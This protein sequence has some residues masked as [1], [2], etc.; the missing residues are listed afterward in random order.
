MKSALYANEK[1]KLAAL[2]LPSKPLSP[3]ME[4]AKHERANVML[5][6][7]IY[8]FLKLDASWVEGGMLCQIVTKTSINRAAYL[9]KTGT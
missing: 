7:V 9:E 2:D 5:I 1:K 4:F 8:L 6:K 3:Y